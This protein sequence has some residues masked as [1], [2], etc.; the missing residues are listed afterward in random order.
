MAIIQSFGA[1]ETVT[2]SCHF[3][4][5]KKGPKILVDCGYFQGRDEDRIFEPFDF[6]PKKVNIL[7]IT[8]GHLDHIGRIPKLVKEGFDGKVIALRATMDLAEV[9]LMDSA[10][11]AEEDYKTAL[12]KAK[13]SGH[14]KTVRPPI[15]TSDDAQAVFDLTIQ[16]A[17]YDKAIQ[18]APDV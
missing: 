13:R 14:E 4:Q 2:G 10:K 5:L 12:K 7:L 1:A 15:Y 3:L 18:I 16:Y 6:D 11:I 8:H 9:I 17:H